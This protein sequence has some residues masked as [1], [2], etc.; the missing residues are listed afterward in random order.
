MGTKTKDKKVGEMTRSELQQLIREVI[1]EFL[2]P[3]YGLQLN[4]DFEE[5]LKET[6]KQK[7]RGEGITFE[8][9]K[10]VLGLK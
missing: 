1:Y 4:P 7:E 8:E 10:K 5:S 6:M 9:A 3:D 2:D